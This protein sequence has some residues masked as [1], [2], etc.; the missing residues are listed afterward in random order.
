MP[1]FVG[2]FLIPPHPELPCQT[3]FVGGV[4]FLAEC[5]LY[6]GLLSWCV[7]RVLHILPAKYM[8]RLFCPLPFL[9]FRYATL[10]S[11]YWSETDPYIIP[12]S[13]QTK[14]QA[15]VLELSSRCNVAF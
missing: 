8:Y 10:V 3:V 11:I 15:F 6:L 1:E 5:D 14:L 2:Y 7:G 4:Y 12:S 9:R 13:E